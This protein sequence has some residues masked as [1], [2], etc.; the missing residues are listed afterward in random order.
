MVMLS[1]VMQGHYA[2]CCNSKC[3]YAEMPIVIIL[4]IVMQSVMLSVVLKSV[5]LS[6]VMKSVIML[7][8]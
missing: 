8:Y 3:H 5:I 6:V 4:I 1:V 2:D 7:R